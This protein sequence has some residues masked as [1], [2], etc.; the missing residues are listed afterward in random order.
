MYSTLIINIF[1]LFIRQTAATASL[2]R[3]CFR[4][5]SQTRRR[6]ILAAAQRNVFIGWI[7]GGLPLVVLLETGNNAEICLAFWTV[8]LRLP[9]QNSS[10]RVNCIPTKITS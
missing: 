1:I 9:S 7:V 8:V 6:R 10:V 2:N 3:P 5:V 4:V